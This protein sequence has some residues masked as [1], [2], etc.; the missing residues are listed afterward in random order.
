MP[1]PLS[2]DWDFLPKIWQSLPCKLNISKLQPV[3]N[4]QLIT[5]N[6]QHAL[7]ATKHFTTKASG[8]T[9]LNPQRAIQS[10]SKE[11]KIQP[12]YRLTERKNKAPRVF[13]K[14]RVPRCTRSSSTA[15]LSRYW[16]GAQN[17]KLWVDKNQVQFK[18]NQSSITP[19]FIK[20]YNETIS[21]T[22]I[23]KRYIHI[24]EHI[25]TGSQIRNPWIMLHETHHST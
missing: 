11:F 1:G 7:Q 3:Q 23:R 4:L 17:R 21:I 18:R 20:T 24:H 8:L 10:I 14:T 12:K 9:K 13:T 25:Y 19:T 16:L 22:T 5:T 2:K 15:K 6:W